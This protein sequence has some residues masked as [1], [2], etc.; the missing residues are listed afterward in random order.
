MGRRRD[1]PSGLHGPVRAVHQPGPDASGSCRAFPLPKSAT[2][3]AEVPDCHTIQEFVSL[4]KESPWQGMACIR[5]SGSG[6]KRL[7]SA[8]RLSRC[9][10]SRLRVY[11]SIV[12]SLSAARSG[13]NSICDAACVPQYVPSK[14][15]YGDS[16]AGF[17]RN[18][19]S[20]RLSVAAACGTAYNLCRT[21]SE[22]VR[23]KTEVFGCIALAK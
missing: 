2:G 16:R 22:P 14:G 20:T 12:S 21:I 23:R 18:A 9:C 8:R 7:S 5:K 19:F 1:L 15:W 3:A 13:R 4:C 11:S 17:G 6:G 10:R